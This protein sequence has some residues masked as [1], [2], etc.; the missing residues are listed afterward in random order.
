MRFNIYRK[1]IYIPSQCSFKF[2][3]NTG[4][5]LLGFVNMLKSSGF[6]TSD[7]IRANGVA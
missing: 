6:I 2:R 1:Y 7:S 3:R 5:I 4:N